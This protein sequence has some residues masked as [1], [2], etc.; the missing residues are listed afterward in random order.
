M[1]DAFTREQWLDAVKTAHTTARAALEEIAVF[2]EQLRCRWRLR[3]TRVRA[4]AR[5][6]AS[7]LNTVRLMCLT[8]EHM[9]ESA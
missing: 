2:Q 7:L 3:M 1:P 9:A 8:C 6:T 4:A 5:R